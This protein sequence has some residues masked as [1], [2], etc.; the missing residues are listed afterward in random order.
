MDRVET[1]AKAIWE[2][3]DTANEFPWETLAKKPRDRMMGV[4]RDII[5]TTAEEVFFLKHAPPEVADAG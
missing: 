2:A 3:I 4:A 5:Y 1:L